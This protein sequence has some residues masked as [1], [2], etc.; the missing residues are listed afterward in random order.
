MLRIGRGGHV[1][2]D[3]QTPRWGHWMFD[4]R[5]LKPFLRTTPAT[6]ECPVLNCAHIVTRQ[7]KSFRRDLTFRCPDH[8]IYISPSTFEYADPTS[9]LLAMDAE[10]L[11]LFAR[12]LDK[13]AEAG[14]LGRER[15][16]DAMTFNVV[17]ALEREN[18]LYDLLSGVTARTISGSVPSYWSLTTNTG[19]T[20]A[21]LSEAR[22]AFSEKAGYGTEP[23]LTIET[24]D[25]LFVVEAKLGPKN[26]TRP[27]H[28]SVLPRYRA[29]ANG[30][31]DRVL[32][33]EPTTVAVAEKLYQLL[34]CWLLGTWMA[35]RAH[36]RFVLVSLVAESSDV[37]V[38]VRFGACI[39]E[40]RDRKFLR[41]SWEN[42][43]EFARPPALRD[44]TP[45]LVALVDYLD[46]KTRGY[47]AQGRLQRAFGPER[48]A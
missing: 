12:L 20:H 24:S 31:Y 5:T 46:H 21:L 28:E 32:C 30:W 29:G 2:R 4:A 37:S 23:D 27:S 11:A 39:R 18:L 1:P 7:R 44:A 22:L 33:A 6:V 34:R 25:A 3:A 10:D 45:R 40:T 42:I 26:E 38:P 43:R 13:K 16:E 15:S 48:E 36:K 8:D 41:A 35:E 47:D 19:E 14:R 9:N 17:R